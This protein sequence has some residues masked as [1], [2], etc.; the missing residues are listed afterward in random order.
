MIRAQPGAKA[1]RVV[2]NGL[3][4]GRKPTLTPHHGWEAIK[5]VDML[6]PKTSK[7]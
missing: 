5:R 1:G 7:T 2:A 6:A 4:L 3:G